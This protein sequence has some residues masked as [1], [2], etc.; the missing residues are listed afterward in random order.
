MHHGVLVLLAEVQLMETFCSRLVRFKFSLVCCFGVGS[1]E[2]AV[3]SRVEV[4]LEHHSHH[5]LP[6]EKQILSPD[7]V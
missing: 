5:K 7:P 2:N 1:V 3:G 4:F 6:Q